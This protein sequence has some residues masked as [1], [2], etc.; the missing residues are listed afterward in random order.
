MKTSP[1]GVISRHV[2]HGARLRIRRPFQLTAI[3]HRFERMA[4]LVG[5]GAHR[6]LLPQLL[7]SIVVRAAVEVLRARADSSSARDS[8]R[9]HRMEPACSSFHQVNRRPLRRIFHLIATRLS[10]QGVRTD[11]AGTGRR[12]CLRVFPPGVPFDVRADAVVPGRAGSTLQR[13]VGQ[14]R[15]HLG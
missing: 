4:S 9:A 2:L 10:C 13:D 8:Q 3:Q 1:R 6:L 11:E 5:D 15:H 12:T 14:L 7:V